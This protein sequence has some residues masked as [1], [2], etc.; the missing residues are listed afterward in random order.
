MDVGDLGTADEDLI[1]VTGDLKQIAK[2]CIGI[3]WHNHH[4]GQGARILL[5]YVGTQ[6]GEIEA[7]TKV[8]VV[9]AEIVVDV[10]DGPR[11]S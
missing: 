6:L 2:A 9:D 5:M 7:L 10:A 11:A 8:P 3:E 1:R 4:T